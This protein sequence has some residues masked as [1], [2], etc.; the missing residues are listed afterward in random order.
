MAITASKTIPEF[1]A[2]HSIEKITI[3]PRTEVQDPQGNPTNH[4]FAEIETHDT[5]TGQRYL[6]R[7]DITTEWEGVSPANKNIIKA[8]LK[9]VTE[10]C[11]QVAPTDITGD[12]YS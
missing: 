1:V 12:I 6:F 10:L 2:T 11:L 5:V 9:K 4:Y 8:F 3:D 7:R